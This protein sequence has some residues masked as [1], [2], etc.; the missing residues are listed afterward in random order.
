MGQYFFTQHS[1]QDLVE[2]RRFTKGH[3]GEKQSVA[4]IQKLRKSLQLLSDMPLM[5]KKCF[6]DLGENIFRFPSGAHVIYYFTKTAD[7][8]IVIAILHQSMV[9]NKHVDR[10]LIQSAV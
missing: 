7:Q 3:W 6:D 9:P 2:L 10:R 1:Q 8:I 4:Y 5:G